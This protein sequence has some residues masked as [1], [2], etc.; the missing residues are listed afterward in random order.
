[1]WCQH[2]HNEH[3]K[4]IEMSVNTANDN[5]VTVTEVVWKQQPHA[6]TTFSVRNWPNAIITNNYE[7]VWIVYAV[8][9]IA[10]LQLFNSKCHSNNIHIYSWFGWKNYVGF[11]S[12]PFSQRLR[13]GHNEQSQKPPNRANTKPVIKLSKICNRNQCKCRQPRYR[14]DRSKMAL[15][16]FGRC[17]HWPNIFFF[18]CH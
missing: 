15:R 8:P 17:G 6:N 18:N 4:Y 2:K 5:N 16:I 13:F 10:L 1:M 11:S 3:V 7:S 14:A 12:V 9:H